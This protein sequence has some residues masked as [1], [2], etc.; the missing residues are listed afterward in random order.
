MLLHWIPNTQKD[1]SFEKL[2]IVHPSGYTSRFC[3][4]FEKS[5]RGLINNYILSTIEV[6]FKYIPYYL[7]LTKNK[8]FVLLF[9]HLNSSV[10]NNLGFPMYET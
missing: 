9:P 7:S 5:L 6:C 10:I 2:T 3:S 1:T 4:S 8:I